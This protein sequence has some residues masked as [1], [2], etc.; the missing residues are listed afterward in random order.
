LPTTIQN[1]TAIMHNGL[2]LVDISILNV[3]DC[4][5]AGIIIWFNMS[6]HV[7]PAVRA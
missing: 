6:W 2:G 1:T 5:L 3:D 4:C 7:Y